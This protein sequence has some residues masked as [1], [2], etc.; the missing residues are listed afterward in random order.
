MTNIY[1]GYGP[2]DTPTAPHPV[3]QP[4]NGSFGASG[5]GGSGPGGSGFGGGGPGGGPSGS[6]FGG[7]GP[8]RGRFG[9]RRR[10][11]TAVLAITAVVVGGGAF[12]VA[13]AATG[14]PAAPAALASAGTQS[15]TTTQA[16]A[17]TQAAALNSALSGHGGVGRLRRLGG[18]YG[19]FTFAT[20]KG[21]RTLAFERGT[22]ESVAGNDVVVRARNGMTEA[23]TLTGNS[24]VREHGKRTTDSALASG[25]LVFAGGPVTGGAHDIRLIVIRK[26]ASSTAQPTT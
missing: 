22:I 16:D 24:I 21:T 20:K 6:G 14:S 5:P 23:W 18:M 17:A 19:Q 26:A 10:R 12:A 7:G 13:E 8:G 15:S 1:Q 9:G 3:T 11:W 25:E 2:D 4:G